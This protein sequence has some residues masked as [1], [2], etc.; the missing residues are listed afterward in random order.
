MIATLKAKLFAFGAVALSVLAF[1]VRLKV[2]A[3]QRDK[4]RDKALRESARANH[5]TEVA[6][7]DIEREQRT[8]SRRAEARNEIEDTGSTTAFRNPNSLRR[9]RSS[10]DSK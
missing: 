9:N 1:F 6:K 7:K 10:N 4:A 3:N 2:V 5:V 8:E